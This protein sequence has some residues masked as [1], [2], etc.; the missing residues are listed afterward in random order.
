MKLAELQ[1][2]FQAGV[3]SGD[4]EG[5]EVLPAIKSS[6][7]ETRE[8]LFGV[9]V[10]A[11]RLR[12]DEFL[13][14]DY[15]ALHALLGDDSFDALVEDYISANPPRHRNARWYTTA[16]PDFMQA[17]EQWKDQTPAIS[18]ARFERAL[19]DAY[20]A[21]ESDSLTIESLAAFP[22]ERWP[23]LSFS[24]HP[25]LILLQ[26]EN[27]TVETYEALTA[28]ERRGL[29][30]PQGGVEFAAIWRSSL[31]SVYRLIE[32]DEYL[33]LNEARAGRAFGD[34]CQM[35]AFQ[36]GDAL[37]PERLA[38]MLASWFEEGLVVAVR[39]EDDQSSN[40]PSSA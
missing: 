3:L 35:A 38:Q 27:G 17:S 33:A 32:P 5:A 1:A 26:L 28:E 23:E 15:P 20:D 34:I 9:Y 21:A 19:T 16:L 24:L 4:E 39:D 6:P 40:T 25:S 14:E 11:Y 31:E 30:S 12:L 7:Q 22:P 18:L 8:T 2:L 10:D 13:N 37:T 36:Q 29:P